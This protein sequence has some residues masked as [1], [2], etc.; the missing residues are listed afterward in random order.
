MKLAFTEVTE[1]GCS[2]PQLTGVLE[3]LEGVQ[4]SQGPHWADLGRGHAR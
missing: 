2:Q 4:F 3:L 1:P